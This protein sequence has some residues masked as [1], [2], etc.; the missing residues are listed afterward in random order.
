M[1]G[2]M[3]RCHRYHARFCFT[4]RF[5]LGTRVK[6]YFKG[7]RNPFEGSVDH[8]SDQTDFYH[9]SY[10]DGDS[11]EMTEDD[12]NLHLLSLPKPK[13]PPKTLKVT[14]PPKASKPSTPPAMKRDKGENNICMSSQVAVIPSGTASKEKRRPTVLSLNANAPGLMRSNSTTD[15]SCSLEATNESP[16]VSIPADTIIED[17]GKDEEIEEEEAT[18]KMEDDEKASYILSEGTPEE[19][20]L[21][22]G[23]PVERTV[24]KEENG[25]D[26]VRGHVAS[27]FPA[28]QMFRVMY[29]DGDCCDLTYQETL[30]SIPAD[31][32]PFGIIG[33]RKRKKEEPCRNEG[34]KRLS[35]PSSSLKRLKRFDK[36]IK[37]K[38]QTQRSL[39]ESLLLSG[40]RSPSSPDIHETGMEL[41]DNVEFNIVRKVLFIIVST[42]K[43]SVMKM[44]LEALSST[45]LKDKEALEVFVQKDGLT[46]LA[47]LLAKWEDQVETEQGILLVLKALAVLPGVSKD[48][49]IDSRI[50]KKVRGIQKRGSYKNSAIPSLAAWV[51]EKL[52]ADV[53][54]HR[55]DQ[56]PSISVDGKVQRDKESHTRESNSQRQCSSALRGA[57][58]DDRPASV[59]L[60]DRSRLQDTRL[61]KGKALNVGN[62]GGRSNSA[63][64]LLSLMNSRNGRDTIISRRDRYIF[65][66]VV[67]AS[68]MGTT[69]NWRARRSTVVLDQVSKRLTG[70]AQEVEIVK[71]KLIEDDIWRPSKI[72]FADGDA[73]CAFDKDVAVSK[74][75]VFRPPGSTKPPVR[76]PVKQRTGSLR[77]ILR[78]R[79]SP[80]AAPKNAPQIN[81]ENV[82]SAPPVVHS[83]P[84][85]VVDPVVILSKRTLLSS[86]V[87][88]NEATEPSSFHTSKLQNVVSPT[89]KRMQDL[90]TPH[91]VPISE[92]IPLDSTACGNNDIKIDL[93][94]EAPDEPKSAEA[95]KVLIRAL[96][97]VMSEDV[98]SEEGEKTS[99]DEGDWVPK[100]ETATLTSC[101]TGPDRV[102][103]SSTSNHYLGLMS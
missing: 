77:S 49:I 86:E 90:C 66:N 45:D 1:S 91:C 48:V 65:G 5:P 100:P 40:V 25:F 56:K 102:V 18:E 19:I 23:K 59:K 89:E 93:P 14:K 38:G 42:V 87:S 103:S 73:V 64:H 70:N 50:G 82:Q 30:D 94:L 72:S 51:I 13:R 81:D 80:R 28:T 15:S 4:Q 34:R 96:E 43:N 24:T 36:N 95:I 58:R 92:P 26:V 41:V 88:E 75:L 10:D 16:T 52:K 12:V 101:S 8:H 32:L 98:S 99:R 3:S 57:K 76:P 6:K 44:Q 84:S 33:K 63:S 62:D 29:L 60:T 69:N 54:V 35:T 79:L 7:Y 53:G 61:D 67:T 31:L 27:Y 71:T 83:T 37:V 74:L 85:A 17:E 39:T 78:V 22:I 20:N 46:S 68:K 2:L 47:E 55:V 9:I 11:E 97:P 21:L